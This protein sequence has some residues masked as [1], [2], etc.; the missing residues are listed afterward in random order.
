MA[1]PNPTKEI[2]ER[3]TATSHKILD[4]MDGILDQLA[5]PAARPGTPPPAVARRQLANILRL[6]RFCAHSKCRRSGNCRGEPLHCL[7]IAVPLLP[8]DAFAGIL[9]RRRRHRR[10]QPGGRS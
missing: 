3:V 1:Q 5:P 10:A 8:P 6:S 9:T 4:A 2:R 7:Q